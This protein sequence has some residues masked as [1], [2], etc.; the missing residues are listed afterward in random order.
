MP[1][2]LYGPGD[3]YNLETS[4]VIPALIRKFHNAKIKKE[5]QVICWGTGKPKREF[6]FVDD[7]SKAIVH[8]IDNGIDTG[9]Y[10]IGSG[11]E[12]S[13]LDLVNSLRKII[14]YEGELVFDE[15]F[16]DGNPRKLIDSTKIIS[17][18]WKPEVDLNNGLQLTYDWFLEN[19]NL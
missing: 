9:L 2:N 13:I 7:L 12:V 14:E 8:L 17:T 19:V 3:N 5:P 18:G 4:H 10:N 16:P 11:I 1:T 6:L 15:S